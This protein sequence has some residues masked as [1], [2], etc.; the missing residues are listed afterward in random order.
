MS[1]NTHRLKF[2]WST[3]K[4][5]KIMSSYKHFCCFPSSFNVKI[6]ISEIKELIRSIL[7]WDSNETHGIKWHR[8]SSSIGMNAR[9][10]NSFIFM[11][12]GS[13]GTAKRYKYV[14]STAS[15]CALKFS[16][17]SLVCSTL[18][19][20][21]HWDMSRFNFVVI[22]IGLNGSSIGLFKSM[23]AVVLAAWTP[24]SVLNVK[25]YYWIN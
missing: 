4:C 7:C 1:G 25:Q 8:L 2:S 19:D 15:L 16:L 5:T 18:I 9:C 23:W 21:S 24:A 10:L 12:V 11:V 22:F 13:R 20:W 6:I 17:T 3:H 14:R